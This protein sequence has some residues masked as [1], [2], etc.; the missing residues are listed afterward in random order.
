M[1]SLVVISM[2]VRWRMRATT[3]AGVSILRVVV[4]AV[5]VSV[6]MVVVRVTLGAPLPA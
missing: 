1:V 4:V 6:V 3:M 2:A 5:V